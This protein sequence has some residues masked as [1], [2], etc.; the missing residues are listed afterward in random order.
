MHRAEK[1]S[2]RI[3]RNREVER[4]QELHRKKIDGVKSYLTATISPTSQTTTS[5]RPTAMKPSMSSMFRKF[6][7]P[8]ATAMTSSSS[9]FNGDGNSFCSTA[10]I[11]DDDDDDGVDQ[12]HTDASFFTMHSGGDANGGFASDAMHDEGNIM[13]AQSLAKMDEFRSV[14]PVPIHSSDTKHRHQY[15]KVPP[16]PSGAQKKTLNGSFRTRKLKEI[17][18]NNFMLFERIKKSAAHYRNDD[19]KR[20]WEQNVSYLSSIC[21]FPVAPVLLGNG[22]LRGNAHPLPSAAS[23]MSRTPPAKVHEQLPSIHHPAVVHPIR[24]IPTSPR[25]LQLNLSPAFRSLRKGMPQQPALPPITAA[26]SGNAGSC[27]SSNFG[28]ASPSSSSIGHGEGAQATLSVAFM[29]GYNFHSNSQSDDDDDGESHLM[30]SDVPSLPSRA[31][32]VGSPFIGD[33]SSP[34]RSTS[35]ADPNFPASSPSCTS[36]DT[37]KQK[38]QLLKLGRFVG[39]AY[40][41]LTVFCGD[42]VTNPY[43]FDIF[44]FDRE[45]ACEFQLRITKEM[46]HELLDTISSS[47]QAAVTAA[48]AGTNLSMEEIAKSICDHVNFTRFESGVGEMAFL[49]ASGVGGGAKLSSSGKK[50]AALLVDSASASIAFCIHQVVEIGGVLDDDETTEIDTDE[51]INNGGE[52]GGDRKRRL[53][54]FASTRP[55][56]CAPFAYD[57]A[58]GIHSGGDESSLTICFHMREN[59][60][61]HAVQA[62]ASLEFELEADISVE[63]LCEIVSSQSGGKSHSKHRAGGVRPSSYPLKERMSIERVVVAAIRHL[64]IVSVPSGEESEGDESEVPLKQMLIVNQH[65][66]TLLNSVASVASSNGTL[67]KRKSSRSRHRLPRAPSPLRAQATSNHPSLVDSSG[68]LETGVIWKNAYVLARVSIITE[69][70]GD[71]TT[72]IHKVPQ[73]IQDLDA[74]LR[75]SVYNPLSASYSEC[76]FSPEQLDCLVDKLDKLLLLD[77]GG[78]V[79]FQETT[80]FIK[81]AVA[82]LQIEVDLF[83]VEVLTFPSLDVQQ[84][85]NSHTSELLHRSGSSTFCS[86]RSS[87]HGTTAVAMTA[88]TGTGRKSPGR[89]GSQKNDDEAATI[90]QAQVRGFLFRKQY[91]YEDEEEDDGD[92]E[93]EDDGEGDRGHDEHGEELALLTEINFKSDGECSRQQSREGEEDGDTATT[94]TTAIES[95]GGDEETNRFAEAVTTEDPHDDESVPSAQEAASAPPTEAATATFLRKGVKMDNCY[96]LVKVQT[97]RPAGVGGSDIGPQ[98]IVFR[99]GDLGQ[100]AMLEEE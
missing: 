1:S 97:S 37:E 54:V 9:L 6:K 23:P 14:A 65:V 40:L 75:F 98:Q 47:S 44:A 41:V 99:L 8:A 19:L 29:A 11:G 32:S 90:I 26:S 4:A 78:R 92:D 13:A 42:G 43:G 24:A 52:G 58:T 68:L 64:H 71:G 10:L 77:N 16:P 60:Q 69:K 31:T 56:K 59:P 67:E 48:A 38:Y 86:S 25:K 45:S 62:V 50:K 21:E 87:L 89:Q 5:T 33:L 7:T 28:F 83:G 2:S 46:T 93:E 3:C 96:C 20:E 63:E 17:Q 91:Y 79:D 74:A 61:S 80:A 70:S 88:C 12:Q 84:P 53:H 76:T 22:A 82:R 100:L 39:G 57:E 81:H 55:H 95:V 49:M 36:L 34:S 72:A 27:S 35:F 15:G 73:N 94:T 18:T 30:D 85:L 51:F 66:N